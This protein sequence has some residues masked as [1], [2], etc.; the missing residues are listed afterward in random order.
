MDR[1]SRAL[2]KLLGAEDKLQRIEAS[3]RGS[4]GARVNR[5]ILVMWAN[6]VADARRDVE[7]T[8]KLLGRPVRPDWIYGE[9]AR[10][11]QE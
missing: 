6:T 9:E 7:E 5:S 1:D 4:Q 10:D 11:V 2:V 8:A 3:I